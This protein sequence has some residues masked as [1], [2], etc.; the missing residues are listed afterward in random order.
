MGSAE[1]LRCRLVLIGVASV[2]TMARLVLV[3]ST[4]VSLWTGRQEFVPNVVDAG[5]VPL[6]TLLLSRV[7]EVCHRDM[8]IVEDC[9]DA[10]AIVILAD[11]SRA[12]SKKRY[13]R[14]R[15]GTSVYT[16]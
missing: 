7:W 6:C 15:R 16:S 1:G 5:D 12:S 8:R 4:N 11:T 14:G 13:G 2:S 3:R 9:K 10:C